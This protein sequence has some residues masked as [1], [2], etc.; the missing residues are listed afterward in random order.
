MAKAKTMNRS[1][2]Q[3]ATSYAPE[4]FFTFEGGLGACIARSAVGEYI[5]LSDST[6]DLIFERMNEL[7][8]A[9]FNAAI[10]ARKD[11]TAHPPVL[12]LQCV[13]PLLLDADRSNFQLPGVDRFYLCKPS[14][15]EYTPA[16][17]A[18][19]CRT[20]GMFRDYENINELDKE[21][22]NLT[23]DRCPNPKSK[24]QCDWEQLDVIFVHWSGSW[25]QPFPGQWQW[26]DK[27]GKAVKRRDSCVCGNQLFRINRRSAAIGDWFFE[28]AAC[29]KPL[30][31]KWLQNDRETLRILG[32][33]NG[34]NRFTDVRMQA[35]PYRASSAYYVKSD[36]FIDFKDG[37]QQLLAR[38]RPGREEELRDFIANQYG[39]ATQPVTDADVRTACAGKPECA[40]DLAEYLSAVNNINT[41]E[42]Q[43]AS[44]PASMK[45]IVEPL[46]QQSYFRP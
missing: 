37:S 9:W 7:G 29:D 16:P 38:L 15:M 24:K 26:S 4:S 41:V 18:F 42:P 44:M 20:C 2:N 19:A 27:E 14:H 10:S 30:S 31:R 5:Q 34:P 28:C 33:L 8:R 1:R 17:L 36:L 23:P 3:L 35:A 46:L 43:L 40:K 32:P 11:N 22:T 21:L 13:D 6:L 25:E 12:P 39:F 45:A